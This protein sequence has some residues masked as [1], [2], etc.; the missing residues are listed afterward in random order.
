MAAETMVEAEAEAKVKTK[1]P[2][3]DSPGTFECQSTLRGDRWINCVAFSPDGTIL[4]GD[5]GDQMFVQAGSVRF[6]IP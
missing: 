6:T 1:V 4:A 5:D 2:P 3:V